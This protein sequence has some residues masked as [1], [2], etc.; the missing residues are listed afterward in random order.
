MNPGL[1]DHRWTNILLIRTIKGL[2]MC[3]FLYLDFCWRT[4][5]REVFLFFGDIILEIFLSSLLFDGI[6][7]Q[8]F[9]ILV[10]ILLSKNSDAFLT[11]QFYFVSLFVSLL[12]ILIASMT[13]FSMSNSIPIFRLYIICSLHLKKMIDVHILKEINLF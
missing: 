9:K 3:L 7:F 5:F 11:W 8:Y 13:H 1:S 2:P 6:R 4:W 12:L 10:I